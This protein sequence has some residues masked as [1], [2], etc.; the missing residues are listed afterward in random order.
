MAPMPETK[1]TMA[2][3]CLALPFP[4]VDLIIRRR[5]SRRHLALCSTHTALDA[6]PANGPEMTA[7]MASGQPLQPGERQS[8]PFPLPRN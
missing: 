5:S 3:M 8:T 2:R 1:A 6:R 7:P 4:L